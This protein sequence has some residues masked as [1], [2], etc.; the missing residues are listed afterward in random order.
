VQID[1]HVVPPAPQL[2]GQAKVRE[3]PAPGAGS[4]RHEQFV[5]VRVVRDDGGRVGLHQVLEPGVRV[6]AAQRS[7]QRRGEL[8]S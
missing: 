5:E 7:D 1:D 6:T 2:A 8:T 4:G 3:H